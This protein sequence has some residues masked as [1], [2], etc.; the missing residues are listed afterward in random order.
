MKNPVDAV[1]GTLLI[2][3]FFVLLGVNLYCDAVFEVN[4]GG[5]LKRAADANSVE[6]A[7]KELKTVIEYADRYRL[8]TGNTSVLYNTPDNDIEFWYNNLK[9]S[10]DE[11]LRVTPET[12]QLERTNILMK[13]RETLMDHGEKGDHIT[14]PGGI[15][16]HPYNTLMCLLMWGTIIAALGGIVAWIVACN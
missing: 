4:C 10:H 5:H 13:L 2:I 12:S 11:L 6:I 1:I 16:V 15:D 14:V 8:T 3:P 7:E 9:T